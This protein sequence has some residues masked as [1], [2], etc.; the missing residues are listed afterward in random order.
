SPPSSPRASLTLD[1]SASPIP[2]TRA[3]RLTDPPTERTR[4]LQIEVEGAFSPQMS[5]ADGAH[6]LVRTGGSDDGFDAGDERGLWLQ[7]PT[8][9]RRGR[10]RRPA[11][12]DAA[13]PL[14]H[15]RRHPAGTVARQRSRVTW[16]G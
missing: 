14:L 8:E 6:L 1:W 3:A 15:R 11:S 16:Q 13:D 5:P 12:L 9:D 7:V 2:T 10:R 4:V